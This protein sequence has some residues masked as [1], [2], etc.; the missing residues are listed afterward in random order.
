MYEHKLGHYQELNNDTLMPTDTQLGTIANHDW[1][2][3]VKPQFD[4]L[5]W[6]Y[7]SQRDIFLNP[8]FDIDDSDKCINNIINLSAETLHSLVD[9]S[10]FLTSCVS[11]L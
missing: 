11:A 4:N 10:T 1:W 7:Y 2:K 9:L 3:Y 8:R 5:I 6:M